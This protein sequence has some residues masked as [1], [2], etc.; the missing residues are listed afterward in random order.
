MPAEDVE[1]LL[2]EVSDQQRQTL[3]RLDK[4]ERDAEKPKSKD[5]WDK[6]QIISVFISGVLLSLVGAVFTVSY[7][8]S[9]RGRQ[10]KL[11]KEQ[12]AVQMAQYRLQKV[13]LIT[14]LMPY[15]GAGASDDEKREQAVGISALM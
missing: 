13:D 6:F 14:K 1:R 15:L 8:R 10:D 11:Q 2:A 3:E 9:E 4:L 7:Q 12:A 5:R